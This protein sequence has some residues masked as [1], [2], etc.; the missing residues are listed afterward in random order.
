MSSAV[1]SRR[2]AHSVGLT[3]S[4]RWSSPTPISVGIP[5]HL[6]ELFPDPQTGVRTSPELYSKHAEFPDRSSVLSRQTSID[7]R[8]RL[9]DVNQTQKPSRKG[10]S[11]RTDTDLKR[12]ISDELKWE[13]SIGEREIGIAVKNGVVTLTGYVQSYAEKYAAER[14]VERIHGVKAMANDLHVKLPTSLIRSDT[15]IAHAAVSAMQWDIQVP[16]DRLRA[17]VEN[18]WV[19][20]EGDVEWQ[21]QRNAAERAVRYLTGVKG[22]SNLVTVK[23]KKVSTSEVSQQ[24]K[25]ALKRQAEVDAN[26]ISIESL[27]GRVTLKGTVRSFAEKDEAELAAWGAPGVTSVED[28]IA[29]GV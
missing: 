7:S 27:D 3:H 10:G 9:P 28:L 11:M 13:P 15:E 19:T 23:P 21:Y 22:V 5:L 20:L 17:K 26:R 1:H 2:R 18:G 6:R 14:A 25:N 24:I 16:D 8:D 29:I 4:E 12:D